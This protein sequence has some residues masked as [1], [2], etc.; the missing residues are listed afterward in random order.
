[1]RE[2]LEFLVNF[3]KKNAIEKE[4]RTKGQEY[5]YNKGY[6]NGSANTLKL[7]AKW[8]E[9]ILKQDQ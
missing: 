6:D 2:E 1:M 8:I 3:L 7:C 5:N 4:R 9:E